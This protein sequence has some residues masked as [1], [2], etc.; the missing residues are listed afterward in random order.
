MTTPVP[1]SPPSLTTLPAWRA[2][3]AHAEEIRAADLRLLFANDA[4]RG[5]RFTAEAAGLYLDYSKNRITDETVRLLVGLADA[6]GL[7]ERID[8]MFRG[9]KINTTEERAVLHMA[10]R[11]PRNASIVLDG[12]DVVPR[13]HDVLVNARSTN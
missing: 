5:E 8:A 2:V 3:A 1:P 10:L 7:R 11:A 9:D 13:V 4:S 12:E 6:C